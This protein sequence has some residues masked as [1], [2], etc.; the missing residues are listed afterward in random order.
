MLEKCELI[1]C[2]RH[3]RTMSRYSLRAVL[4]LSG[5]Q[6][7]LAVKRLDA[8]E[9]LE[10]PGLGQKRHQALL[11]GDLRIALHEELQPQTLLD[12]GREQLL[13]LGVL[14]EVVRGKHDRP[15][16]PRLGGAEA[17]QCGGHALAANPPPG[18]LDH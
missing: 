18:D 14:V 15:H 6:Q 4:S 8:D 1:P 11:S 12:D 2:S 16:A 17:G 5:R 7:G 13:G 3:R 9:H 10:A